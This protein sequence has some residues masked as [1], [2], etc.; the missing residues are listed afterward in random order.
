VRR[1]DPKGATGYRYND[2]A[3]MPYAYY[4][5]RTYTFVYDLLTEQQRQQCR[6]VMRIR[7]DEMY[8]H[9]H[10]RHLWQPYS[11]HSN[12]AWHFLGEIGIAFHGEIPE[13]EDWT[14]FA[15]NV[16]FNAYPVWSDDD[17][18]WHEGTATGPATS[19]A[20]LGGPT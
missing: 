1:W 18:G 11:S 9:L 6:E 16:F 20:S 14:W 19:A 17:G 12:R 8:R 10:P 3:G 5:A 13:A 15:M 4:F 7:G 2:E